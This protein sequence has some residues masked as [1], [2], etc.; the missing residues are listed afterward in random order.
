MLLMA[1]A[2]AL[3]DAGGTII[4]RHMIS[5]PSICFTCLMNLG[6]TVFTLYDF[7][8][9]IVVLLEEVNKISN[10][11]IGKVGEI[12]GIMCATIHPDY[13]KVNVNYVEPS[14]RLAF[15]GV[16]MY[17]LICVVLA[18]GMYR[19]LTQSSRCQQFVEYLCLESAPNHGVIFAICC[20][21]KTGPMDT[22]KT[23]PMD[24]G[25]TGRMDTGKTGPM[26][27]E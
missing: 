1:S 6:E 20:R 17:L 13:T 21:G 8:S 26:D 14:T 16:G 5:V 15:A 12:D 9:N 4:S 11:A 10:A 25:K 19:L 27:T 22:G 2:G 23:G 24:T 7:S 3:A 18:I